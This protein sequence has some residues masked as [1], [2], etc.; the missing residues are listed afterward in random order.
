MMEQVNKYAD[1]YFGNEDEHLQHILKT[2][3]EHG[4][5]NISVS[6]ATGKW[7]TLLATLKQSK[8]H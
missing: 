5:K 2:I 7:L 3:E 8:K 4:M 1:R 6:N